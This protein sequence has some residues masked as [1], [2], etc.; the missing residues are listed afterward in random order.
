[1]SSTAS[2]GSLSSLYGDESV[3]L[4]KDLGHHAVVERRFRETLNVHRGPWV[5]WHCVS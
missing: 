1:M 2:D 3:Q 4:E 5:G